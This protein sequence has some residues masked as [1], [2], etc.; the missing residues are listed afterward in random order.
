MKIGLI[1]CGRVAGIHMHAY[2]SIHGAEVVAVADI[3]IER[4]KAFAKTYRISKAYR[5]HSDLLEMKDLD[6]V[7][8]CTPTSTHPSIA[9]DAARSGRD[10]LLEKPMALNTSD[11]ER[12]ISESEKNGVRFCVCHNQ[13]FA[14]SV[15]Q[16]RSLV[17]SESFDLTSFKTVHKENFELLRAMGLANDWN[18][19]AE[20]KG[21]LWEV[22]CHHAYLQ[23]HFLP[24]I[25]EVYA[26]GSKVRY[27]VYDE[28]TVLLRTPNRQY[29]VMD[30][31]WLATE[32]E[33]TYEFCGSDGRRVQIDLDHEYLTEKS[34]RPPYSI[35]DAV[36][37]AYVD[38]KRVL[39]KWMQFGVNYLRKRKM[40]S[41]VN[42][43]G[44]FV[45]SL[46]KDD[47]PP[48]SPEDGRNAIRLLECIEKSLDEKR[49]V[50][51]SRQEEI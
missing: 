18:V 38:E 36:R 41:H 51:V 42:L 30:I 25:S 50:P 32:A 47:P 1:G 31:S 35:G 9:C 8:I 16:A 6:F 14:P 27:P 43:I 19:T 15:M 49:P 4:A 34:Q 2:A 45:E 17:G 26:M 10:I 22:G 3:D 39:K 12:M 21:V 20:Q 37:G 33:M 29:G 44:N 24:N 48:V 7:D 40:L 23:L 28:F 11:C 46:E 13:L 5:D